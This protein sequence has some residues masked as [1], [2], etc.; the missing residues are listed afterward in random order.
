[1]RPV[2]RVTVDGFPG[3]VLLVTAMDAKQNHQATQMF[4]S[5]GDLTVS[6]AGDLVREA[7]EMLMDL[8][9]GVELDGAP[10]D[11]WR[12]ELVASPV[13]AGW[14]ATEI[15]KGVCFRGAATVSVGSDG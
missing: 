10:V 3:L 6:E 15:L 1:M 8:I 9:V 2:A 14:N 4:R 11:D 7:H 5:R 13:V 12:D